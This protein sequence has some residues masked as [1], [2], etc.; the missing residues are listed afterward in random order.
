MAR[1]SVFLYRGARGDVWYM[2]FVDADGHQVKKRMGAV[3]DG[4][5]KTKAEEALGERVVAV[6][7][8]E[9]KTLSR[10]TL[11]E[12][13][14]DLDTA[15]PD[16]GVR[17]WLADYAGRKG[18]KHST[19]RSYSSLIERHLIPALGH[20]RLEAIDAV[21]IERYIGQ[22]RRTCKPGTVNRQLNCLSLI[23][24]AAIRQ[25]LIHVNP[26][27]LV[28]RPTEEE[29]EW[30]LLQPAE[31]RAVDRA[32]AELIGEAAVG[33]EERAW[34]ETCRTMFLTS[35]GLGIRL[36]EI[37]GL[38]WKAVFL[39]DPEGAV[40]R[41]VETLVRGRQDTPKS[42]AGR[43]TLALG[44]RLADELFR[45]RARS[46]YTHDDD[47]VF[48]SPF[49]GSPLN[50]TRYTTT[51]RLALG[52][53]GISDYVRPTHD[54][55]HTAI[56]NDSAAGVA[57]IALMTRAGHSSFK[58]TQ[59][60][61]NLAGVVFREE[62]EM[63]ERRVWGGVSTKTEYQAVPDGGEDSTFRVLKPA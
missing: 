53:A 8:G 30:R 13:L 14:G 11:L 20:L 18:L 21:C 4:W 44:P 17:P 36:G 54:G 57:P 41:V 9:Y 33:S 5:T 16:D 15:D 63:G 7:K 32:F 2:K 42:K 39:A 43:R 51:F 62:A 3:R 22:K 35:Y 56:T 6:R 40:L 59:R 37:L 52:R 38:K 50:I 26:L 24:K 25:K 27:A 1:G 28:E 61:I 34:R 47:R 10:V 29:L 60:Y 48:V 23:L 45:H 19:L 31:I 55:R 46:L 12:F 49:R 58:T